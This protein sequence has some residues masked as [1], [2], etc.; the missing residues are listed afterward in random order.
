MGD[1]ERL[2]LEV[3]FDRGLAA[4]VRMLK[5]DGVTPGALLLNRW[6]NGTRRLAR[7]LAIAAP[8]LLVNVSMALWSHNGRSMGLQVSWEE[9]EEQGEE[10][11]T[12]ALHFHFTDIVGRAVPVGELDDDDFREQLC[13]RALGMLRLH[14]W[15]AKGQ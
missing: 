9:S 4:A 15:S 2:R 12:I 13:K 7:I 14:V 3:R 6:Q 5:V 8:E 10:I 11:S 1:G